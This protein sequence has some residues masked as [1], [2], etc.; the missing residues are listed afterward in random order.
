MGKEHNR[1]RG[2]TLIFKQSPR[3][4][5]RLNLLVYL[6]GLKK[7]EYILRRLLGE[8]MIVFPT[9]RLRKHLMKEL[10]EIKNQLIELKEK[11]GSPS[12]ELLE[13]VEIIKVMV[14]DMKG[15]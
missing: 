10:E 11:G 7:Q 12:E 2:I 6:S 9:P 3:E 15:E 13:T 4:V 1:K 8:P 5:E 14:N